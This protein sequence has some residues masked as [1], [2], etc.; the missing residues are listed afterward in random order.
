MPCNPFRALGVLFRRRVQPTPSAPQPL[1]PTSGS[2]SGST[3]I[4][5]RTG[6][7]FYPLDP[8][9]E[10]VDLIDIAHALARQCRFSGHTSR[11]YS[12]AEHSVRVAMWVYERT[13]DPALAMLGLLHDASEAYL[14]DLP[15]PLKRDPAFAAYL[16]AERACMDAIL[17]HVG[18]YVAELPDVVKRADMALLSSEARV[19][20]QPVSPEWEAEMPAP[21]PMLHRPGW[22]PRRAEAAFARAFVAFA[23]MIEAQHKARG[24]LH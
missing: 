1:P 17:R 19:F 21:E 2:R 4:Q 15:R 7:R 14:V 20:M 8:R 10:D 16:V 9:P 18:I 5:T 23:S 12:V 24:E 13:H 6:R 11:F 3:W 22:S